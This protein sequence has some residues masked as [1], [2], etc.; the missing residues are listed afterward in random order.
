M[1]FKAFTEAM[2]AFDSDTRKVSKETVLS[3]L[4]EALEKAYRKQIEIPDALVKVDIDEQTGEISV[5]QQYKVVEE[6]EDEELEISLLDARNK[7]ADIQIDDL[8]NVKM[9]VDDLGRAAAILAKNV[10]KQKIRE[11][12]KQAVYDE[13]IDKKDELVMGV[14][15][16]V[17]EKFVVVN[18]GKTLAI[19]KYSDQIPN[20]K[21]TEGQKLRLIITEVS[22]D[23]KGAQVLV[24][25][26]D[27]KLVK[28]LFE[29]EVPEIFQGIVEIKAIARE[30][31]ERTKIAVFS[32]REDVDPIGAC[33]GPKGSRV[34]VVIEE[35]KGEK[36]DI[37]EWSENVIELIR[38]SLSPAQIIGILP[39][40]TS[41]KIGL[42]VVV[43][44]NQLS[45]A[46]GKKGKNA[47]LAVR[48]T[49]QKI[50]IKSR[51][52]MDISG[53]DWQK[54]I[55]IFALE[56]ETKIIE[57]KAKKA[58]EERMKQ[59][60]DFDAQQAERAKQYEADKPEV[61]IITDKD[62]TPV[63]VAEV[64][65]KKEKKPLKERREYVSKFETLADVSKQAPVKKEEKEK[66]RAKPETAEE[67]KLKSSEIRKDKDYD[68]KIEYTEEELKLIEQQEQEEKNAPWEE[69]VDYDEFEE[70]YEDEE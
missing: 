16:S 46:I 3:A 11:A 12:E 52:D 60:A 49:G 31:G 48:L 7:Q 70:Y 36:I 9:N 53:R 24:S 64:K 58:L 15:E 62:K 56:L 41:D 25:R 21:Y 5:Y 29:K 54:E 34:Q 68:V 50:D 27:A 23:T 39:S 30:A 63:V 22:K 45:L 18:L 61:S 6:V 67:R 40:T 1:E 43:E 19:L 26:S 2:M 69:E 13:Y 17:E 38:N 65:V 51:T 28:R 10:L 14:I 57:K 35:L 37:F 32:K 42:I 33:I 59:I 8:Y 47:K 66:K 20:E 44:D 4:K 55:E